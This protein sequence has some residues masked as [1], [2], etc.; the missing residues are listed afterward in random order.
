M[1]KLRRKFVK[2]NGNACSGLCFREDKV[3]PDERRKEVLAATICLN[4][5][6][7]DGDLASLIPHLERDHGMSFEQIKIGIDE[8]RSETGD[9]FEGWEYY[10][11]AQQKPI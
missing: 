6:F 9:C 10:Y 8:I 4:A 1:S 11:T 5:L 3:L 7:F 2:R